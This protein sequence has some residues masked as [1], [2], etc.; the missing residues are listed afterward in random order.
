MTVRTYGDQIIQLPVE[1]HND[2]RGSSALKEHAMRNSHLSLRLRTVHPIFSVALLA[3]SILA[4][5]QETVL[6]SF[7]PNGTDAAFPAAGLVADGSG[8]LYSTS[9]EGGTYNAGAVFELIPQQGGGWTEKLLYSFGATKDGSYPYG[10][11]ILDGAGNLYGTTSQGG[12]HGGGIVFELTPQSGG[13]WT[14]TVLH[15]LGSGSDGSRPLSGLIFDGAGN[16]YGTTSAGGGHGGGTVFE[17]VPKQGGGF[18]ESVIHNFGSGTDGISPGYGSLIFDGTGN[19]YGTTEEGGVHGMGTVFEVEP[20]QGGGWT[21]IVLHPF[22]NN[23]SDGLTPEAG[24]VFDVHGNLFGTTSRG[25]ANSAGTFYELSPQQGG[26]WSET[27]IHSFHSLL[28][29]GVDGTTPVSSLIF[30]SAGNVYGTTSK[31]GANGFGTVFEF[32]PGTINTWTE[33]VLYNFNFNG[34]DGIYPQA[35]LIRGA[36][37]NLYGTSSAG[38]VKSVG[39]VFQLTPQQGGGW[40]ESIAYS[41]NFHGTDGALGTGGLISD[42]AGNFYGVTSEGGAYDA[43]I[44]FELSPANG[45]G[46]TETL[47]HNFGSGLDGEQPSA[48]LI[49]DAS[50][51]FY[52]TTMLGGPHNDGTVFEISPKSGGGWTEKALHDFNLNGTDGALPMAG[53]VFDSTG[54]L[55]GTTPQGGVA[56]DGT[57]F[58]LSPKQGGGWTEKVIHSFLTIGGSVPYAGLIIDATGNLYGTTSQGGTSGDGVVF[59]LSPT[60]SGGWLETVLYAFRSNPDGSSPHAGLV[61]DASGNLYGTTQNGGSNGDGTVFELTPQQNGTWTETV[62]Y[63]FDGAQGSFPDGSLTF[64]GSPASLFGTTSSGGANNAG[65]MFE[66]TPLQGG[67]WMETDLHDFSPSGGD[68]SNPQGN[69]IFDA[70]GNLY[71]TTAGG[72]TYNSG[73]VF[74]VTP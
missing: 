57:V 72:G 61:F 1:F 24:L 48:G 7:H 46:W 52:G 25:G 59:E 62:L 12:T 55:Y 23:G 37:G 31:G 21:E 68:G 53:L 50:G 22:N 10:S 39:A 17:M 15:Y 42:G 73:T 5:G 67:G 44:A 35:G 2:A 19:L 45:G 70:S 16:L 20:K 63:S 71:G 28:L 66:L 8:N 18:T 43:G 29:S 40:Q 58:Q 9:P 38:G 27:V 33:F 56:G 6:H 69:V 26:A 49:A 13:N 30:D 11:L 65:T 51:N 41:F 47:M 74:E 32:A 54:N 34:S 36:D 64:S 3:A 4:V 14:E 60:G